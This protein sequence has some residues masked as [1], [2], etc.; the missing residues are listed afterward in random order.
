MR[1]VLCDV[2]VSVLVRVWVVAVDGWCLWRM[3]CGVVVDGGGV[4]DVI[5]VVGVVVASGVVSVCVLLVLLLL[6]LLLLLCCCYCCCCSRSECWSLCV[7]FCFM[8]RVLVVDG[9]C[10]MLRVR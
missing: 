6:L 9:D 2:C 10:C 7:M 8:C 1:C 3:L 5:V 4:G